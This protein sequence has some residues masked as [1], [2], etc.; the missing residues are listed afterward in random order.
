MAGPVRA[1]GFGH[2]GRLRAVYSA[3]FG[4]VYCLLPTDDHAAGAAA[5]L[6]RRGILAPA[7]DV[8]KLSGLISMFR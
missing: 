7:G 4:P 1:W 3:G 5:G 6:P 8:G 2:P